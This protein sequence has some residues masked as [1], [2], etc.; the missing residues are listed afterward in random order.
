MNYRMQA[1]SAIE[2]GIVLFKPTVDGWSIVTDP[3]GRISYKEN[4]IG[5]DYDQV[6]YAQVPAFKVNTIY[7]KINSFFTPVWS[8]IALI[9]LLELLRTIIRIVRRDR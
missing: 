6:H 1:I 7:W 9:M 5:A 4:T 3:Y 2:T 8:A